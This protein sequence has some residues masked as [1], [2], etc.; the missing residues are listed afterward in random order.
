MSDLFLPLPQS[1]ISTLG[2][3]VSCAVGRRGRFMQYVPLQSGGSWPKS[4]FVLQKINEAQLND[5]TNFRPA[6]FG[7]D[8]VWNA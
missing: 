4:N 6:P 8:F 7:V 1:S 3:F 5:R 2:R